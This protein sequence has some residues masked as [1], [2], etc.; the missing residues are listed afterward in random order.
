[1]GVV[2]DLSSFLQSPIG[3]PY[4]STA[5]ALFP[6]SGFPNLR[7]VVFQTPS[8]WLH[9][10]HPSTK[11]RICIK[12]YVESSRTLQE[13]ILY[14]PDEEDNSRVELEHLETDELLH[15]HRKAGEVLVGLN[16]RTEWDVLARTNGKLET[17]EWRLMDDTEEVEV[18]HL[19]WTVRRRK[20]EDGS[21]SVRLVEEHL[22]LDQ[23]ALCSCQAHVEMFYPEYNP[24]GVP[25]FELDEP[26]FPPAYILDSFLLDPPAR[27]PLPV[28]PSAISVL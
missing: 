18:A 10:S 7:H 9:R 8:Y 14:F 2:A 24:P 28:Y 15:P 27:P 13:N 19:R 16:E 1:L 20:G 5:Q 23:D 6:L 12:T 21:P 17:V 3:S 25:L 22:I 4:S 26:D 11:S